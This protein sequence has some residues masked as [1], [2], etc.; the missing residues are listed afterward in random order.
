MMKLYALYNNVDNTLGVPMVLKNDEIA[1]RSFE[2]TLENLEKDP[3]NVIKKDELELLC[4]GVYADD[5]DE[6]GFVGVQVGENYPYNVNTQP[7]MK[8]V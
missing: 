4:I 2:K 1:K 8:G 7:M 3:N 6:S 5:F